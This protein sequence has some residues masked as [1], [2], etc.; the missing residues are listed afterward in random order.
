MDSG[1]RFMYLFIFLTSLILAA[2]ALSC[3]T[4]DL[5][6]AACGIFS[7]SM[8]TLSCGMWN[9]V[10]WPGIEPRPPALGAWGL[11]TGPPGKSPEVKLITPVGPRQ[12]FLLSQ[13]PQ[14]I[15]VTTFL[16]KVYMSKPTSSNSPKSTLDNVSKRYSQVTAMNLHSKAIWT[17]SLVYI[18]KYY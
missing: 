9:L 15:F 14:P 3:S 4:Q 13:G 8:R 7:Y 6:I 2:P 5:I 18:N 17:Y 12:S 10:P 11:A 16:P 1:V